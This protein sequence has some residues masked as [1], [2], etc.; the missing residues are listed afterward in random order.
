MA[1]ALKLERIKVERLGED[2]VVSGYVAARNRG[3]EVR[4]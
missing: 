1:E 3:G 2:L 4:V